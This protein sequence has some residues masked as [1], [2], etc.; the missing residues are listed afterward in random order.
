MKIKLNREIDFV[1]RAFLAGLLIAIGAV[2]Y[3][4]LT[5]VSS[6][7][8][9][10]FIGAFMFCLGLVFIILLE[11][12]LFTGL[13]ASLVEMHWQQYY[14][15]P[16]CFIFNALGCW[17]GALLLFKTPI[18]EVVI[19]KS[20]ELANAKLS[21]NLGYA[22]LSSIM[23]GILITLAILGFR[24]TKERSLGVGVFAIIFPIMA[25]VLLGVEHSVANQVYF[26]LSCLG[27][28]GFPA[29]IILHTFIVMLGN[30]VGGILIPL[31]VRYVPKNIGTMKK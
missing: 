19:A 24:V 1:V 11:F 30:I 10:K 5:A 28:N 25:F 23:C 4:Y 2:T 17:F 21:M 16:L 29:W 31:L 7:L 15:L 22:F 27:G 8:I 3:L 9:I 20:I 12:K 13:N 26:A 6:E 14:R 18:G